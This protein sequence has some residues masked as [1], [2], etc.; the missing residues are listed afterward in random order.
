MTNYPG[1]V[2]AQSPLAHQFVTGV[3][4]DGHVTLA[5]P[6]YSDLA[7]TPPASPVPPPTP[8]T[9]GGLFSF[10]APAHQFFTAINTT[11]Q[12]VAAQPAAAD[13]SNGVTGSGAVVL[14]TGATLNP[15]AVHV[16]TLTR[17]P[18]DLLSAYSNTGPVNIEVIG[19][20][21]GANLIASRFTNDPSGPA[22]II[23]KAR[24]TLAA[25]LAVAAGDVSGNFISSAWDGSIFAQVTAIIGQVQ[26][27]VGAGNISGNFVFQTRTAGAGG[28]LTTALVIDNTQ[29]AN[30][31][32]TLGAQGSITSANGGIS[33]EGA[34]ASFN[35]YPRSGASPPWVIYNPS[36]NSLNFYDTA[37]RFIFSDSGL[38]TP[39]GTG[40]HVGT[41]TR[42]PTNNLSSYSNTA[43]ASVEAIGDGFGAALN[44]TRFT[45][46]TTGPFFNGLKARGT[47]AAPTAVASGDVIGSFQAQAYD[48]SAYQIVTAIVAQAQTFTGPGNISGALSLQTRT[49]GAG[50]ALAN[51]LTFDQ[52]QNATFYGGVTSFGTSGSAAVA[53]P[54]QI[55]LDGSYATTVGG[56]L[57]VDIFG[58]TG[59][60]GMGLA[61]GEMYFNAGSAAPALTMQPGLVASTQPFNAPSYQQAGAP[62]ASTNLADVVPPTAFTPTVSFGTTVGDLAVSYTV[63]RGS[64][65]AVGKL[66]HVEVNLGFT[67][68]Y[69]T[70]AGAL[71]VPLPG[72]PLALTP[73]LAPLGAVQVSRATGWTGSLSASV[74]VSGGVAAVFL[75]QSNAG[76][77]VQSLTTTHF[78]TGATAYAISV[79]VTYIA[80]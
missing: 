9:L 11:G 39:V 65:S 46:D 44:A 29:N 50:G 3:G 17:V 51:A 76:S 59:Q 40:V 16:G 23:A 47:L 18:S 42:V 63:Q 5:Q 62:L 26:T 75:N 61:S 25:P 67:L 2:L 33:T 55:R 34:L 12:P 60:Y 48:G 66:T 28:A 43:Q 38:S 71:I 30:F 10:T 1:G 45:N 78:P 35:V 20:G 53:N 54:T 6:N 72:L 15:A 49:A 56:P 4:S 57:K 8:T 68:T 36:G 77:P 69:T 70:S 27:F 24:G 37:D 32:G 52:I 21:F 80:A 41:L 58:G 73:G 19:D 7:G 13:L 74:G 31:Y 64:W 14:A 79:N 22:T